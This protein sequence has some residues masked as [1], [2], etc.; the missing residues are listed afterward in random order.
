MPPEY[1]WQGLDVLL[2][3][4]LARQL[5]SFGCRM[6]ANYMLE[7]NPDI[8]NA[9]EKMEMKEIKKYRVYEKEL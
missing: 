5:T 6:E 7:N 8:L 4:S 3:V 9:L 2:Y 1:H